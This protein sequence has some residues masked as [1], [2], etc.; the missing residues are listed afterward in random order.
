[1]PNFLYDVILILAILIRDCHLN[2]NLIHQIHQLR[3]VIKL[4]LNKKASY[5]LKILPILLLLSAFIHGEQGVSFTIIDSGFESPLNPEYI[6]F[7]TTAQIV[8]T[9]SSLRSLRPAVAVDSNDNVHIVWHDLTNYDGAGADE[10]IFYKCWNTTTESWSTTLVLSDSST[11]ASIAP[12]IATDELGN[13]HVAWRDITNILSAGGDADVFYRFWNVTTS[14]WSSVELVSSESTNNMNWLSIA[15]KGGEAF[16]VWQDPTDY[17]GSGTDTDLLFKMRQLDGTWTTAEVVSTESWAIS[18]FP[19]ITVDNETNVHVSWDDGSDF[20]G[21]G[22]DHTDLWST[23]E[24]ISTESGSFSERSSIAVDSFGNKHIT[25]FDGSN[26]NGA[27][28][29]HDVF[30][31][32][33]N[34]STASWTTTEVISTESTG[35]SDVPSITVNNNCDVLIFWFDVTDYLGSG[36]DQDIFYKY[37]NATSSVWNSAEVITVGLSD[38]SWRPEVA[39]DSKERIHIVWMDRTNNYGGSGSDIDILYS[40]GL[41]SMILP[42]LDFISRPADLIYTI[43]TLGNSLSWIISDENVSAPTYAIY[44]NGTELINDTWIS[45]DPI[46]F[47]VDSLALG[48]YSFSFVALDGKGEMVSDEVEVSV[49]LESTRY[50]WI[51][52][53]AKGLIGFFVAGS[54]VFVTTLFVVVVKRRKQ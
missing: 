1:L 30:Y 15:A 26:Y 3:N 41:D 34:A 20:N 54:T 50:P 51:D 42:N 49:I 39:I 2:L 6:V 36:I 53:L 29:D 25:W 16:V 24:V 43:N 18:R 28:I 47:N 46:S 40:I 5:L 35:N 12:E 21:A 44:Q 27:G 10:D 17:L 37:W 45:N 11:G 48:N 38:D 22:V 19:A 13:V 9:E 23:T 33:W 52:T 31:K 4:S 7:W 8:S 14:S 32:R